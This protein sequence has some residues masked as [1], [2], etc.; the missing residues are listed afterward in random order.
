MGFDMTVI[1]GELWGEE[2]DETWSSARVNLNLHKDNHFYFDHFR[3][4][5]ALRVGCAV[6]SERAETLDYGFVDGDNVLLSE[7]DDIPQTCRALV[8]DVDY[9]MDLVSA[10]QDLLRERLA[11]STW[12]PEMMSALGIG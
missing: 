3:T 1:E 8:D 11:P 9:R 12:L 4:V 10:G 5:E 6:V 2:R 7:L